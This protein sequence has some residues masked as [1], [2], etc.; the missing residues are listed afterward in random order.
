MS[1]KTSYEWLGESTTN[2]NIIPYD[3]K[4]GTLS[5]TLDRSYDNNFKATEEYKAS[6]GDLQ[7]GASSNIQGSHTKIQQVG[8]HNLNY[9]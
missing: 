5:S 3:M 4:E 8:I 2:P 7:N 6:M 9:H 1:K